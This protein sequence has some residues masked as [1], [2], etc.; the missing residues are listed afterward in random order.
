MSTPNCKCVKSKCLELYCECYRRGITC[1]DDCVCIDCKN[2]SDYAASTKEGDG[3]GVQDEVMM[4]PEPIEVLPQKKKKKIDYPST[5]ESK[6]L[7]MAKLA[8]G[9]GCSCKNNK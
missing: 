6:T 5:R 3:D 7:D 4:E 2:T 8:K 1:T 9:S